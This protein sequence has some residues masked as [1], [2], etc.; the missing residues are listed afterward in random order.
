[1]K[2]K[3]AQSRGFNV[4]VLVKLFQKFVATRKKPGH[5][6]G[7]AFSEGKRGEGFGTESQGLIS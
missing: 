4:K 7:V 6:E 3:T 1:M 2:I 5:P